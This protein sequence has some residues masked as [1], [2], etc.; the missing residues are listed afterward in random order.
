L[1]SFRRILRISIL[2]LLI[3]ILAAAGVSFLSNRGLPTHS[4]LIDRLDPQEKSYLA[5]AL[6]LKQT[7]GESLWPDW[8]RA[9][10]P[11]LSRNEQYGFLVGDPNPPPGWEQVSGDTFLGIPYYRIQNPESVAFAVLIG[12]RWAASLPTKDWMQI[13]FAKNLR[14][15]MPGFLKP[16]FPYR[17][18]MRL[19]NLNSSDFH[20]AILLHESFHAFQAEAAPG[21]FDGAKKA[22]RDE[23]R[24]PWDNSELQQSWKIELDLLARG[25]S[26]TSNEETANLAHHFLEH[27][28]ERRRQFGLDATLE[29]YERHM[30]WLE[31]LAKYIELGVWREAS[32]S[33]TY[34]P[35]PELTVD[36]DFKK[37][38]TFSSQWSKEL[39]NMRMQSSRQGDIRFYYSGMAQAF[40]LDRLQPG[41]KARIVNDDNWLE[42]L[43]AEAT[44]K[45]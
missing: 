23:P 12:N 13:S 21:R 26:A 38:K 7:V 4:R 9:E 8:S 11:L 43:L 30:E 5:E 1:I 28:S 19:F 2:S 45:Q 24:Y 17:L 29:N 16:V 42:G 41:W 3:L 34:I 32:L 40:L 44:E 14:G 33:G 27:R 10:I 35:R 31:G 22:Y 18:P 20:I 39:M 36:P 37:Y 6:H 15:H 25:L